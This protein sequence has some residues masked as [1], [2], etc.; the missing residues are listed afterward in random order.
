MTHDDVRVRLTE[1][2][3][4]R[5]EELGL[6][7][8]QIAAKAGVSVQTLISVRKE[9]REITPRTR[10]A[11]ELGLK[12][13][14]G[15]VTAILEDREPPEVAPHSSTPP[16]KEPTSEP[17]ARKKARLSPEEIAA[18]EAEVV[19][20][21]RWQLAE[22]AAMIERGAGSDAA[23]R[24]MEWAREVQRAARESEDRSRRNAPETGQAS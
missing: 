17:V 7:W 4:N 3:E 22:R 1:A 16:A 5:Q 13:P 11:I 6:T 14:P 18:I 15:Y 24:W 19:Q 8:R 20:M 2:M 10:R 9:S 21:T 23:G 12:W